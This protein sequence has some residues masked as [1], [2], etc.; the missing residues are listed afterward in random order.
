MTTCMTFDKG[1]WLYTDENGDMWRLLSTG[2]DP[3]LPFTIQ[4]ERRRS[5][6]E[7]KD[8]EAQQ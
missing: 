2:G 8:P 5:Y 6:I 4:L 1:S 3:Q 7:F